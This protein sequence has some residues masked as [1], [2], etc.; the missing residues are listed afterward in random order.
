MRA[1]PGRRVPGHVDGDELAVRAVLGQQVSLAGAAT[2]A[3]RL[4]ER[5]GDPLD[6]PSGGVTHLFPASAHLA[7]ADPGTLPMPHARRRALLGLTHALAHGELALDAGADRAETQRRLLALPGIGA[8]TVAY[9][10]MRALRDP[11]AFP[12]TDLGVRHALEHLGHDGRPPAA[13]RV[14]ERWRPYRAYATLYLWGQLTKPAP[15]ALV[16]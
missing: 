1:T 5:Y 10:A 14:A 16:A 4:V 11:D 12:A 9:I 7:D 6:R 15:L 13:L 8:W 3:G 2:V